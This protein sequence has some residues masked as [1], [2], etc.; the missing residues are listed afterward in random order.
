M[1]SN[2]VFNYTHNV[3]KNYICDTM[4]N[5]KDM[6]RQMRLLYVKRNTSLHI[7]NNCTTNV[8]TVLFDIVLH[9]TTRSTFTIYTLS[10]FSKLKIGYKT[11]LEHILIYIYQHGSVQ[12]SC[13]SIQ[14]L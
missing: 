5:D 12:G 1:I 3:F 10:T 4:K 7:F 6:S 14:H 13:M 11:H 9:I 2:E 8:N